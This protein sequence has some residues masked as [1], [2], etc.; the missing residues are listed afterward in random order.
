MWADPLS[1]VNGVK[2]A[3]TYIKDTW[4][5]SNTSGKYPGVA[6]NESVLGLPTS[7]DVRLSKMDFLRCRSITLGY[8]VKSES[9]AKFFNKL[10]VYADIQNSFILTDYK[11]GDPEV[12][13][14]AIKGGP[15]PYPMART[16]S[17]GV[18]INF[19]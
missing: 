18:N 9:I 10:R 12:L 19:K 2:G 1:F 3:T 17:V 11:G 4:T 15:A 5:T 16:F 13:S 6:Y 7:S 14:A 8:T